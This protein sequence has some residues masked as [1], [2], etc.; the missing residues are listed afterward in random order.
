[1]TMTAVDDL[2]VGCMNPRGGA[3][4]CPSCGWREGTTAEVPWHLPPRTRLHGQYLLGRVLGFG[5]FGI[6]Y[7]AWDV[8]LGLKLAVKEYFPTSCASRSGGATEVVPHSGGDG[9]AFAWGLDR[10]LD[11]GRALA[12]FDDHPGIVRVVNFFRE[13]QTAYL[14]MSFA[15]GMTLQQYV[16]A[17]GGAVP[18]AIA[19]RVLT[20]VMDTLRMVHAAGVLHRDISPDNVLITREGPVKLID[21]GAARVAVGARSMDLSRVFKP[22]YA[23]AEQYQSKAQQGPWTDVY[24]LAGTLYRAVAGTVPPE[25]LDRLDQDPLRLPSALGVE[26]PAHAERALARALAVRAADRYQSVAEFQADLLATPA[27]AAPPATERSAASEARPAADGEPLASQPPQSAAW[28]AHV[29]PAVAATNRLAASRGWAAA[30][31][32]GRQVDPDRHLAMAVGIVVA[33]MGAYHLL[34]GTSAAWMPAGFLSRPMDFARALAGLTCGFAMA[35]GG[36]LMQQ[37]DGRGA[38]LVW[39]GVWWALAASAFILGVTALQ[40]A[41]SSFWGLLS[42]DLRLTSLGTATRADVVRAAIVAV[43]VWRRPPSAP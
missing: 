28:L 4:V 3:E 6:T 27:D 39:A 31:P 9:E 37:R 15:D 35:Y 14:V 19:L 18:W 40:V 21:F 8:N 42:W 30:P 11:E 38:A 12:R 26:I 24:A 32:E 17:K 23:P 5:G 16:D 25:A 10:F 13:N 2:C 7:L 33:L 34:G 29:L 41:T 20:P 1:M 36:Y 43:L 22:G